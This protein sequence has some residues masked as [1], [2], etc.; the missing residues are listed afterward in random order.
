MVDLMEIRERGR[1]RRLPDLPQRRRARRDGG[2]TQAEL[3]ALVGVS[4][5]SI[6]RWESGVCAPR[7]PLRERYAAAL[8]ELLRC[9]DADD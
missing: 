5:V 2:L 1:R 7:G 9:G 8:V 6:A 4:R 3:A